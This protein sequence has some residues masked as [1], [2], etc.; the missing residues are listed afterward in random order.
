M[1]PNH[2]PLG[3]LTAGRPTMKGSAALRTEVGGGDSWNGFRTGSWSNSIDV[4]DY[5]VR[6]VKPHTRS[7]DFLAGP[8]QRTMAVWAKLQPYFTAERKKGVLDVHNQTP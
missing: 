2:M 3:S 8:S 6:N 4:R 5:T 7:E 1:A